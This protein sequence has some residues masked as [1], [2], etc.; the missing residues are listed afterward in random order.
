MHLTQFSGIHT[1]NLGWKNVSM[2]YC[3][4]IAGIYISIWIN[5]LGKWYIET[6]TSFTPASLD[7]LYCESLWTETS[8]KWPFENLHAKWLYESILSSYYFQ[9]FKLQTM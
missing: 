4:T 3:D 2:W 7:I 8:L 9:F 1:E 5:F 6:K